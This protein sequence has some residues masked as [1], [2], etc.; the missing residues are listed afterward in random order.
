MGTT[1]VLST[2]NDAGT[3]NV[4]DC[5]GALIGS[6]TFT[7]FW[8]CSEMPCRRTGSSCTRDFIPLGNTV[9]L[10][11]NCQSRQSYACN[12]PGPDDTAQSVLDNTVANVL[13][14][15]GLGS[16]GQSAAIVVYFD[17]GCAT[18]FVIGLM[19]WM[20]GAGDSPSLED[21]VKTQLETTSFACTGDLGCA[22]GVLAA[23]LI[24][25]Y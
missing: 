13:V 17:A 15:C 16:C 6:F 3:E 21:C 4:C 23:N 7:P 12:T 24:C 10:A 8:G 11:N 19:N 22:Q 2:D 20:A 18:S 25:I 14:A 5:L 9:E 1:C